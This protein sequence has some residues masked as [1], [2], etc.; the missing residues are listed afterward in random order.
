MPLKK[1]KPEQSPSDIA[2][3]IAVLLDRDSVMA[4][5]VKEYVPPA[6][7]IQLL[8]LEGEFQKSAEGQAVIQD[9]SP[10]DGMTRGE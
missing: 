2:A 7:L 9:P 8:G 5:Q 3:Q 4:A 1:K 6:R 10:L